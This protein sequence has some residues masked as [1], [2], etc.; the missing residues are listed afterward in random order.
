MAKLH[1]EHKTSLSKDDIRVKLG[2]VMGKIEEK[3]DIKGSWSGD[4]YAFSRSGVD[5]KASIK[6]GLVTIDMKLG[7]VLSALKG[8]IE[9]EMVSKLKEGLP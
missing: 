4:D 6:D 5:G 7:L 9:S 1:I 3:F 2:E 8:R